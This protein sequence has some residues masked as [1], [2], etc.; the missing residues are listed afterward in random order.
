MIR[1][2][3]LRPAAAGIHDH[4]ADRD[5]LP[6]EVVLRAGPARQDRMP[7]FNVFAREASE[8]FGRLAG[9]PVAGKPVTF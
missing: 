8:G 9:D 7:G 2:S 5:A 3:V 4:P 6:V 1:T